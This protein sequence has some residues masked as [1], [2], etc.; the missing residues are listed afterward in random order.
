MHPQWPQFSG[1][2]ASRCPPSGR[3]FFAV[4]MPT[5]NCRCNVGSSFE[6]QRHEIGRGADGFP[7]LGAVMYCGFHVLPFGLVEHGF[8]VFACSANLKEQ[9]PPVGVGGR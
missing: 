8:A 1:M 4:Q 2:R 6:V 3:L 7:D 9:R 5:E